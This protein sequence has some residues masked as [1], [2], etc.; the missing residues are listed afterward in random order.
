MKQIIIILFTSF[1]LLSLFNACG[2]SEEEV[3]QQEQARQDSLKR[4][5][6]QQQ[7][8][9]Q[10]DTMSQSM[11]QDTDTATASGESS[12]KAKQDTEEEKKK[13]T[14]KYNFNENGSLAIQV[15]AWRSREKA[16]AQVSKWVNRGFDNAYVVM[17]GNKDSGDIW[18]RVRLGRAATKDAAEQIGTNIQ[19]TY[20]TPYWIA[21][22]QEKESGSDSSGN[23]E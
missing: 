21:N 1:F 14:P 20:N 17:H 9:Q 11:Q 2:P 23:S 7:T 3:R 18:F 6:Q 4:A 19:E 13:E 8:Q 12:A 16:E 15:E 5:Q 10:Q 22:V